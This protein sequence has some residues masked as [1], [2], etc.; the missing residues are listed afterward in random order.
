[1]MPSAS[2]APPSLFVAA[3]TLGSSIFRLEVISGAAIMKITSSTS[4]TSISG[5][6]LM[7]LMGCDEG[8]RSRRPKAM[9]LPQ[10]AAAS[11]CISRRSCAKPSNSASQAATR[12][13][14][15]L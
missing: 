7:S 1:M 3:A 2:A 15:T 11:S 14:K 13:P 10:R 12:L 8:L 9:Q 6:M 4:I 5:V